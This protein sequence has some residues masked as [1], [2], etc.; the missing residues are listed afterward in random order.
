MYANA[1]RRRETYITALA[2][3]FQAREFFHFDSSGQPGSNSE[4][5]RMLALKLHE[6]LTS[7]SIEEKKKYDFR[8]SEV[9]VA[10]QTNGYDCGVHVLCHAENSTRHFLI[11]GGAN[12]LEPLSPNAVKRKRSEVLEIINDLTGDREKL[13]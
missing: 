6:F 5:A 9:A 10:R 1:R 3:C 8:F 13:N 12:G 7:G 11:Y 2:I 4:D